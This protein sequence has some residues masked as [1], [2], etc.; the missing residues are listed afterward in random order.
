MTSNESQDLLGVAIIGTGNVARQHA[1]AARAVSGVKLRAVA[2]IDEVRRREWIAKYCGNEPVDDYA[3]YQSL[4]RRDDI[5]LVIVTLPHWLHAEVA[6]AAAEAGKHVIVEKPMALTLDECDRMIATARRAGVILAV[7]LTHHFHALPVAAKRLLDSNRLGRIIWGSE[8]YYVPRRYGTTSEWFFDRERGGGQLL[9]NGVHFID[10][11]L[12][13]V[14]GPAD[15]NAP[16]MLSR[17]RPVAVTASVG[18][19]FNTHEARYRADDG[20]AIF[21]RFDT[22]QFASHYLTGHFQGVRS[23]EAEYVCDRG[24]VKFGGGKLLAT[25]PDDQEDREYHEMSFSPVNGF[26]LQ[27]AN[28]LDAIRSGIPP[29]VPGEWGRLVMQLLL[30]AEESSQLGK[31]VSLI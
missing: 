2:D 21:I 11:L 7:G 25:N 27:L 8:R 17:A 29:R 6:T 9:S 20:A 12:W 30:A 24:M 4:L 31:E 15:V 18:T 13:T 28:V 26:A 14:A 10:R 3:D 16:A 1:E 22:G 23:D 5:D 19:Y